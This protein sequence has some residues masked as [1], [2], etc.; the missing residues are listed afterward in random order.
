MSNLAACFALCR[1]SA[2]IPPEPLEAVWK[3]LPNDLVLKIIESLPNYIRLEFGVFVRRKLPRTWFEPNFDRK[4]I[5]I[6]LGRKIL[7]RLGVTLEKYYNPR[8]IDGNTWVMD[9]YPHSSHAHTRIHINIPKWRNG[10]NGGMMPR[11][12]A[13]GLIYNL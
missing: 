7:F 12:P 3:Q 10:V 11:K 2:P 4:T 13:R 1:A 8:Q 5:T 6:D 9:I